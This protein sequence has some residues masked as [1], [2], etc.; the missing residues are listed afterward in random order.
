MPG[1]S[2]SLTSGGTV[3]SVPTRGGATVGDSTPPEDDTHAS[4]TGLTVVVPL[5]NEAHRFRTFAPPLL[6][7]V[8]TWGRG[9][10][11]VFVD[12]GSSDDTAAQVEAFMAQSG[13]RVRLVRR[14]HEGK[15]AA[16]SAGLASAFTDVAAFCDLDLSTPLPELARIVQAAM[17]APILAI[18]SRGAANASLTRRQH[19]VR[20]LLGR[21]YNR[22]VQLSVVPGVVDTQCGAKAAQTTIWHKILPLC[23]ERGFAWDVEAIAMARTLGVTVQEIGIEWHHQDGSRVNP[24]QDGAD[25]LRALPRIRRNLAATLRTRSREVLDGGGAFESTNAAAL[26]NADADH[27]WFR[28]KATFVS[29]CIRRGGRTTGWL[30]DVGAGSGG[31]S[32]LLGWDPGQTVL[33]EGSIGLVRDAKQRHALI[34]IAGDAAA[35][36]LRRA[37]ASHVCLLDVIEHLTDPVGALHEAAELLDADGRLIVNVPGHPRLWSNADEVLGHA[38]RYTR[39]LLRRHMREAGLEVVWMSHVF[40]WLTIPVWVKRRVLPASEP[41]LGL[42]IELP[43]IDRLA[44]L[45]TRIE[46]AVARRFPLPIGTSILCIARRVSEARDG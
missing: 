2:G 23:R 43:A 41:Q 38:R 10:E 44:M 27:W 46:W 12:D 45:L 1:V 32:T 8:Q 40:S 18:G 21:T 26:S 17:R 5:Y 33:V 28:S 39:P 24:V 9:S 19:R 7:F 25:M 14:R 4:D 15:G 16:V 6:R 29:M 37:T 34:P 36:P 3:A 31:V 20:E 22:A 42:D 30:V 13:G 35:L 11:L